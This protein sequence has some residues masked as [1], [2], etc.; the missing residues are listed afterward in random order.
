MSFSVRILVAGTLML[1]TALPQL[2][3]AKSKVTHDSVYIYVQTPM[4][5]LKKPERKLLLQRMIRHTLKRLKQ[6]FES[7][8]LESLKDGASP[9]AIKKSS[10]F[11]VELTNTMESNLSVKGLQD[12]GIT[13]AIPSSFLLFIG[14]SWIK[15][16][17]MVGGGAVQ[18]GLVG[19][20]MRYDVL[21][22]ATQSVISTRYRFKTSPMLIINGQ[23][24]AGVNVSA[25]PMIP[26]FEIG[27]G[28]V[29]GQLDEPSD[30]E[31]LA[32]G[33]GY[34]FKIFGWGVAQGRGGLLKQRNQFRF[35]PFTL[36]T[37]SWGGPPSIAGTFTGS[38]QWVKPLG[39]IWESIFGTGEFDLGAPPKGSS[40]EKVDPSVIRDFQLDESTSAGDFVGPIQ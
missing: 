35:N 8:P 19:T 15:G 31:G 12:Y 4:E 23:F 28:F 32:L 38:V 34:D 17:G 6:N 20:L 36:V 26:S 10:D 2:G 7:I 14:G 33:A 5:D 30:F 22:I 9:E 24:G 1:V 13:S 3:F 40:T 29:W 18:V 16:T 39:P 37:K 27:G 11:I 21:D 25:A